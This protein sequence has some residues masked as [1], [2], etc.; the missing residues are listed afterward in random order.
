MQRNGAGL[1]RLKAEGERLKAKGLKLPC[2]RCGN[3]KS[4]KTNSKVGLVDFVR[5]VFDCQAQQLPWLGTFTHLNVKIIQLIQLRKLP[6]A[7]AIFKWL[8]VCVVH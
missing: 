5:C 6:T 8:A 2:H 3:S 4:Q 1:V 7:Y